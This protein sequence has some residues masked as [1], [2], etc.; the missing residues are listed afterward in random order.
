[1]D[2]EDKGYQP[3]TGKLVS[4]IFEKDSEDEEEKPLMENISKIEQEQE[5][6]EDGE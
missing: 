1:M 6:D 5:Q 2:E 3:G 4:N